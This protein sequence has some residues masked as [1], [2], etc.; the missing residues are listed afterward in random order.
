MPRQLITTTSQNHI[1]TVTIASGASLSDAVKIP[2]D[3]DLIGLVMP[4]AWDT[5]DLTLQGSWD[6]T[7]YGNIHTQAGTEVT[8]VAAAGQAIYLADTDI[9]AYPYLK[10][11]SGPS[12]TPVNQTAARTLTLITAP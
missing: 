8:I 9:R 12:A 11:R 10:F 2:L 5:A 4:A 1:R 7:T 6:G 3:V